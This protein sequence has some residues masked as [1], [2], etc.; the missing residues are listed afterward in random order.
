M[1]QRLMKY[2]SSKL[3]VINC[4]LVNFLTALLVSCSDFNIEALNGDDEELL[5]YL[6]EGGSPN[7]WVSFSNPYFAD[8]QTVE[9]ALIVVAAISGQAKAVQI[10]IDHDVNLDAKENRFAICP[11]A[12]LGHYEVVRT[13]VAVGVTTSVVPCGKNGNHSPESIASQNGHGAIVRL[14]RQTNPSR[15]E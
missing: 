3:T 10:L 14:L 9:R 6:S 5:R 8:G 11:A 4:L 13:L 7:R 12:A 1:W 15:Y 2:G